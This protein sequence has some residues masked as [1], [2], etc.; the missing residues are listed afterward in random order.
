MVFVACEGGI[1]HHE[2]EN[3]KPCDLALG[4]RVL[5]AAAWTLANP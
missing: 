3:A 4:T 5:A 1:S 2:A